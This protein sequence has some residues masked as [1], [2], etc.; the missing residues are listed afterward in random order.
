MDNKKLVKNKEK[1]HKQFFYQKP[2][3]ELNESTTNK[4]KFIEIETKTITEPGNVANWIEYILD[5]LEN[6]GV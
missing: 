2:K 4:D 3:L 1:N 6:K 5:T